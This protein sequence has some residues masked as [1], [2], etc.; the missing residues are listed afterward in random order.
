MVTADP[1]RAAKTEP[2]TADDRAP[3]QRAREL[4]DAGHSWPAVKQCM[5]ADF[6]ARITFAN[7]LEDEDMAWLAD[8]ALYSTIADVEDTW[9]DG[10]EAEVI[11]D[12]LVRRSEFP[13]PVAPRTG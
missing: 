10:Q 9:I 13:L 8:S 3:W 5:F 7:L 4:L 11:L 1:E 2:Y 12:E 6:R